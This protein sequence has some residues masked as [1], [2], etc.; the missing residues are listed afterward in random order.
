MSKICCLIIDDEPL[1]LNILEGYISRIPYLRLTGRCYSA[2]EALEMMNNYKIDLL[3]LDI[4]MPELT[5]IEL[6]RIIGDDVK[7]VFTT[8]Y[9]SFA[10]DGF[11]VNALDYLLK[12]FDFEAF[13]RAARKAKEWFD[14]RNAGF[15]GESNQGGNI[16]FIK[17]GYKQIKINLENVYCFEG[18]KDYVKIWISGKEEPIMTL[19][20]LKGLEETLPASRFMRIHRSFIISLD[21][22]KLVERNKVQLT[23][24]IYVTISDPY[25]EQFN[26][27]LTGISIS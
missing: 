19:M 2:F 8:A 10:V 13:Q 17:S 4:Q 5:G 12:P 25:R 1:A 6:S 7:I 26:H 18:L 14:I 9:S 22:I 11:K 3:F 20:S 23:N 15:T 21:K 27:F 24:D 16:I